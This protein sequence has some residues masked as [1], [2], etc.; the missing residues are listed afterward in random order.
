MQGEQRS[1]SSD[2]YQDE[3]KKLRAMKRRGFFLFLLFFWG[4]NV[5]TLSLL[6]A[7]LPSVAKNEWSLLVFVPWTVAAMVAGFSYMRFRCPRCQKLFHGLG[8]DV[9]ALGRKCTS[10][11]LRRGAAS[12]S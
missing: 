3:W 8:G 10:C 11:G 2:L 9:G 6:E 1:S 4:G 5:L 7:L 12:G